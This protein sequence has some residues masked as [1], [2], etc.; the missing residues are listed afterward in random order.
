MRER[1]ALLAGTFDIESKPGRGT[2]VAV[3][4]PLPH[5]E[6]QHR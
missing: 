4:I 5:G 2:T 1:A 3:R 6:V